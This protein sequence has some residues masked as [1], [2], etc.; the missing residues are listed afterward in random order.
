MESNT[1]G[2][3]FEQIPYILQPSSWFDKGTFFITQNNKLVFRF[4]SGE[5]LS[6]DK[7]KKCIIDI[8]TNL[9]CFTA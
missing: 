3:N 2:L 6:T 1:L 4:N 8:K 7:S 9:K 5:Y